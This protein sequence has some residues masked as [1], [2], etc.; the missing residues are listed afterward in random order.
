MKDKKNII[1]IGFIIILFTAAV[2]FV[3]NI[4]NKNK[5]SNNSGAYDKF[6]QCLTDKGAVM[7]GAEWCTHCKAQ[8][9]V[10]GDSFKF[11]KYVEC[12]DNI[13]LCI[14]SGV[15]GYPTWLI[16][17]STKLEGFDEN[18]TMKELSDAT[19]CPLP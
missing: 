13:Q 18:K 7:Y 15:Q 9:A 11:I 2:A 3:I 16:G 8:K 12:P 10:F 19:D 5:V 1:I 14:D 6:A 4:S 17:T